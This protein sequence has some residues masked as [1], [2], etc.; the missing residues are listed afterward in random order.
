MLLVQFFA[1]GPACKQALDGIAYTPHSFFD[2]IHLRIGE[3]ESKVL[4][5][6]TV[7]MEWFANHKGY[8]LIG[9]FA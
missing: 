9:G 2:M 3:T 4:L 7:D 6:S 1:G 8:M 5:T